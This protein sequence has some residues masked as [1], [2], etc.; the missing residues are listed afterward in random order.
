MDGWMDGCRKEGRCGRDRERGGGGVGK[1][2][3]EAMLT[4]MALRG[5]EAVTLAVEW[6]LAAGEK[7]FTHRSLLEL[8]QQNTRSRVA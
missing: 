5:C 1:M 7:S 6:A 3:S 4:C 8:P 2:I